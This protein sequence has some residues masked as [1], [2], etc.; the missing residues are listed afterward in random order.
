MEKKNADLGG[1]AFEIS[2]EVV[3]GDEQ[4]KENEARNDLY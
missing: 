2:K 3:S 4:D 1:R